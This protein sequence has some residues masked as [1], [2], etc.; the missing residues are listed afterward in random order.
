[1]LKNLQTPGH[2]SILYR[3]SSKPSGFRFYYH[4][5]RYLGPEILIH[6][7]ETF[8]GYYLLRVASG[9]RHCLSYHNYEYLIPG[10]RKLLAFLTC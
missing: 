3:P 7:C 2:G 4:G 9:Y 10:T 5:Y 8:Q 6:P 1:M